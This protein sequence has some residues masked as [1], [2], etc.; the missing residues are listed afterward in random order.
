MGGLVDSRA[1]EGTRRE[2]GVRDN[3]L[4]VVGSSRGVRT[5]VGAVM[6]SVFVFEFPVVFSSS[7]TAM[8]EV[9]CGAT[10]ME[11]AC[12]DGPEDRFGG[13]VASFAISRPS[14][15]TRP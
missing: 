12:R 7:S 14:S 6:E 3:A 2:V 5:G 1:V 10:K 8:E 4:G 15:L 9:V 13:A 11:A